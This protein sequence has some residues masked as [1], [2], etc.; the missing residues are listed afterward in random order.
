M[1]GYNIIN[2]QDMIDEL[3]E[4]RV[5]TILLTF[6]SKYNRDVQEFL[7]NKAIEFSKQSI[8]RT[9]LVF[10]S[11]KGKPVLVGYFFFKCK[12]YYG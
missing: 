3:G 2:L 12:I 10:A 7:H 11:F 8:S 9:H 4:D 6:M 1:K 5:K